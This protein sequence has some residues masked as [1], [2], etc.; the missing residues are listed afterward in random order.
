MGRRPQRRGQAGS[1]TTR[2][3]QS[4]IVEHNPLNIGSWLREIPNLSPEEKELLMFFLDQPETLDCY[5]VSSSF[6]AHGQ[7]SLEVPLPAAW[8]IL[9]D[10][11]LACA[12]GLKLLQTGIVTE[13]D[14]NIGLRHASAAMITLK[15]LPVATFQDATLCLTLGSV[16]AFY[17]YSAVGVGVADICHYCLSTTSSFLETVGSDTDTSS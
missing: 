8:P 7:R 6:Q 12:R 9:K 17:V 16:L 11:Y 2:S 14:K 10:A 3:S 13:V 15:S 1:E 4:S 5:V